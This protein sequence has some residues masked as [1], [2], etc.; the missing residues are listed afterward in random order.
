M[1]PQPDRTRTDIDLIERYKRDQNLSLLG[2]L[3]EPYIPVIYGLCLK[4]LKDRE[5]SRDAVMQIFEHLP[6]TILR[7]EVRNFRGWICT[8][9]RNFCLM[10]IRATKGRKWEEISPWIM[11]T[12]SVLHQEDESEL[13][14]NLIKLEDCIERLDVEQKTCVRLF[15]LQQKC[16]RQISEETGYDGNKVKSYI[17]NGKRN[18]KI[19][20]DANG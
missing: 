3:Y 17:Q 20:M 18:L 15:Y 4:Y 19:C 12:D 13:E 2:T 11:E 9:A 10:K 6:D 7:H 5:E 16:Y 1:Q 8:L 14:L